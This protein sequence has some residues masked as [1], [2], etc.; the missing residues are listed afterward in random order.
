MSQG[1]PDGAVVEMKPG[2]SQGTDYFRSVLDEA[3]LLRSQVITG[4][5][6]VTHTSLT[7]GFLDDLI[8]TI[9]EGC[10]AESAQPVEEFRTR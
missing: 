5:A 10:D 3:A 9:L 2:I 1:Q 6:F 8:R 4:E 7:I